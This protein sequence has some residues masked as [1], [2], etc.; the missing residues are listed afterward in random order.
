[1]GIFQADKCADAHTAADDKR[2]ASTWKACDDTGL[3]GCCCRHDAAVYLANI[4]GGG[5]KR[6]YP[7]A[8][9][10]Q[11]LSEIHPGRRVGVLY[12]IG[13]TLKKF[14]NLASNLL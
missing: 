6:K 10:K 2:N 7:L 11:I 5:E 1:M 14:I 12:D 8:I 4:T 9:M 13:C 3:M